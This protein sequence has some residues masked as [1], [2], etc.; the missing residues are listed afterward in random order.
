MA[1]MAL[2]S[3]IYIEIAKVHAT[4]KETSRRVSL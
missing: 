3:H 1:V 4:M 2:Y